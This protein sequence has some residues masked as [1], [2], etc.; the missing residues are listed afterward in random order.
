MVGNVTLSCNSGCEYDEK[1]QP[2][3]RW[4]LFLCFVCSDISLQL[5]IMKMAK[6]IIV[7][8]VVE[9]MRRIFFGLTVFLA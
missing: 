9:R 1:R 4:L 7:R 6:D 8:W 3:E 5:Q 2:E